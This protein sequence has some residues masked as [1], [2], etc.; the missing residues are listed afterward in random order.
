M[1]RPQLPS[2]MLLKSY[3]LGLLAKIKCSICSYQCENWYLGYGQAIFTS[4]S[5]GDSC[6]VGLPSALLGLPRTY[7]LSDGG[8]PIHSHQSACNES[9]IVDRVYII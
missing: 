1:P 4:I 6:P 7:T 8:P 5:S 3:L 9:T 2:H